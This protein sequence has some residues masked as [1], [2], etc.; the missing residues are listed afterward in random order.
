MKLGNTSKKHM[1]FLKS[2]KLSNILGVY[3]LNAYTI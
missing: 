1:L 3:E 2:E